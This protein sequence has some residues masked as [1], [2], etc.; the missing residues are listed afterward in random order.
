[1]EK[2]RLLEFLKHDPLDMF[3]LL[4]LAKCY[5][6]NTARSIY[7]QILFCN[8]NVEPA[9]ERFS[10]IA[11]MELLR[12]NIL[13]SG[14]VSSIAW[15]HDGRYIATGGIDG[16]VRVWE[17]ATKRLIR[18]FEGHDY[19]IKGRII[20]LGSREVRNIAWTEDNTTLL[21]WGYDRKIIKWN[22][23][24][25]AKIE[26][27][28]LD[29]GIAY[30]EIHPYGNYIVTYKDAKYE[31]LDL[32]SNEKINRISVAKYSNDC[33][34]SYDG[35]YLAIMANSR[36]IYIFEIPSFEQVAEIKGRSFN[37]ITW[38]LDGKYIAI[39]LSRGREIEVWDPFNK[40]IIFRI[41][42]SFLKPFI[43]T[44]FYEFFWG[45]TNNHFLFIMSNGKVMISDITSKRVCFSTKINDYSL[46]AT[47]GHK[48]KVVALV[49]KNGYLR[50]ISVKEKG[51]KSQDRIILRVSQNYEFCD[52]AYNAH[53]PHL[54]AISTT[55]GTIEFF[56][57]YK[58]G[59]IET[60][61][62]SDMSIDRLAWSPDD[63]FL[64]TIL[65]WRILLIL[66]KEK[67]ERAFR[68]KLKD[69]ILNDLSWNPNGTKVAVA[70]GDKILRIFDVL[71]KKIA[72]EE[73]RSYSLW[74]V[75]WDPSGKYIA[76]GLSRGKIE[77]FSRNL[78]LLDS[79][80]LKKAVYTIKWSNDGSKL[81][82][83]LYNGEVVILEF[84]DEN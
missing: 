74:T 25:G 12:I 83:G 40:N 36:T 38:S 58:Q 7:Q 53:N 37:S 44:H 52:L 60:K 21:S 19:F 65:D 59:V 5:D 8:F 68:Y 30:A 42:A 45:P 1:M 22:F 28:Q 57:L 71:K 55:K 20:K 46:P 80:N 84:K 47:L 24:T 41:R 16:T 67:W 77:I 32:S 33:S 4:E 66:S 49:D 51:R 61:K 75:G 43:P 50:I 48:E 81:C 10:E 73:K 76:A 11:D 35:K 23:L 17:I 2:G 34:W 82:A 64:A 18:V 13:H 31:I 63:R 9:K 15:S 29:T 39:K 70:C 3:A 79:L 6:T 69:V 26:E 62:I 27:I 78:S 72:K 54:L 14:D 56:D